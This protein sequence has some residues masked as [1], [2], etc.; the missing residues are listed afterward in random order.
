L[1]WHH[2]DFMALELREGYP[3]LLVDFG[4]GTVRM[5][6]RQIKLSDGEI[7]RIDIFWSKSVRLQAIVMGAL[8]EYKRKSSFIRQS[9]KY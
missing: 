2:I 9:C 1:L 5:E 3:V 4:S 7:H 8:C 6:Q